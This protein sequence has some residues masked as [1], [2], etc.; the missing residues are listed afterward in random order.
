MTLVYKIQD[1]VVSLEIFWVAIEC[2]HIKG[3]K[4]FVYTKAYPLL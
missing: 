3:S 4:L 2:V 1:W